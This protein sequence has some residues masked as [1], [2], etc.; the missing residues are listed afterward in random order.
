MRSPGSVT[1][2]REVRCLSGARPGAGRA[3]G[4]SRAWGVPGTGGRR[5]VGHQ[6]Q[7][8]SA[9]E[10]T[11]CAR[12]WHRGFGGP[13]NHKESVRLSAPAG[14]LLPALG[15]PGACS[16]GGGFWESPRSE[17][18]TKIFSNTAWMM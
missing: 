3:P 9:P 12:S 4:G 13:L 1:G 17:C 2:R 10:K 18:Q 15:P 5:H 14:S 6:K 16:L 7:A 11:V 8:G